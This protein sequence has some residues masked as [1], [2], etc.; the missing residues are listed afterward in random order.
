LIRIFMQPPHPPSPQLSEENLRQL[1]EARKSLR[2]IKR[3]MS[4]ARFDGWTI[5]IFAGLT[6]LLG[7]TD[8][9][10]IV[11][12]LA[13]GTIAT[14]ELLGAKRLGRLEPQATRMLGFNQLVLGA[15]LMVYAVWRMHAEMT[16]HGELAAAVGSDAN[17]AQA[18]APYQNL[19]KQIAVMF[20]GCLIAIAIL[21]MG[22]MARYY[23]SRGKYVQKYLKETPGWIIA[24]QKTGASF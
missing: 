5:G 16:G 13:L 14:I 2:K 8:W 11:M 9:T 12:G 17:L 21:G 7:I 23:F 24:M 6:V 22:A 1:A 4:V 19:T 10:N 3:A 18:L 15:G 20:Y